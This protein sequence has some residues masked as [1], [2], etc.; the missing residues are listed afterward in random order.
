VL[1]ARRLAGVPASDIE[2]L[3][4]SLRATARWY[5]GDVAGARSDFE[6]TIARGTRVLPWQLR[7]EGGLAL[8][9]ASAGRLGLA[10]TLAQDAL[11]GAKAS[12]LCR[13][14]CTVEALLAL[15]L[16]D[17]ERNDL[18]KV[19]RRLGVAQELARTG[20]EAVPLAIATIE[21]ARCEL[22]AGDVHEGIETLSESRRDLAAVESSR[23][24]RLADAVEAQL[25][26]A[27]GRSERALKL[28]TSDEDT[29]DSDVRSTTVRALLE[30]RLVDNALRCL[31]DWEPESEVRPMFQWRLWTAVLDHVAGSRRT[32]TRSFAELANEAQADGFAQL[33]LESGPL[34][35]RLVNDTLAL[36]PTDYLHM[37]A[38]QMST[39]HAH[40]NTR[41]G[42]RVLDITQLLSQR[43]LEVVR[44]LPTR[45]SAIEIADH[46]YIS[47]NTLKSHM[48]SIYRKFDV[49]SRPEL[50]RRAE[51]LGLA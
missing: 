20:H 1:G 33:F 29:N 42:E 8:L 25:L 17:R 49:S 30:Q 18:R 47:Y 45:L 51:E 6:A 2:T 15:A 22:A 31:D 27:A 36:Q 50:I 40:A 44:Y 13:H 10:Q 4:R 19:S 7:A 38:A 12:G 14:P 9:E 39:F 3:T 35:V 28:L 21:Q 23:F 5:E 41:H 46:L 43:E 11:A 32:A 37:L 24:T 48:R 26:L 16:V 34:V